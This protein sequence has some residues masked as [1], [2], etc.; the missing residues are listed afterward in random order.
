VFLARFTTVGGVL[1]ASGSGISLKRGLEEVDLVECLD[2]EV[3]DMEVGSGE[4][5]DAETD[6]DL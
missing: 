6:D 2:E 1:G 4:A 5:E 3:L